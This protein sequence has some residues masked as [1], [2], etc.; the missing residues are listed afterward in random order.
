MGKDINSA[1]CEFITKEWIDPF[2]SKGGTQVEFADH[3]NILESTVRKIKS[4]SN[5]RIPV[6]T[7][8]KICQ[9]KRLDISDFFKAVEKMFPN[10]KSHN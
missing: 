3:H 9:E 7:L 10:L 6:E 8:F 1:I 5:Y 4:K 2:L